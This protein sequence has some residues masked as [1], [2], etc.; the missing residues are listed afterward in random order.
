MKQRQTVRPSEMIPLL[1]LSVAFVLAGDSAI[2]GPDDEPSSPL[3]RLSQNLL[4]IQNNLTNAKLKV[5][6]RMGGAVSQN[7]GT[8]AENGE[9]SKDRRPP[10]PAE[11]CC[12]SNL[13]LIQKRFGQL[14]REVESLYLYYADRNN[15]EALAVLNQIQGEMNT[16]AQGVAVFKMA[17][18]VDRAN[19]A[20]VGIIRPFNR[21]RE[22]IE[23][24][25]ACCPVDAAARGGSK[26]AKQP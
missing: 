16:V 1:I 4:G 26:A 24:L 23:Q 18:T 25:Q 21:L 7:S 11:A 13:E 9:D 15:S 5:R 10:T 3:D 14:H 12:S 20:M 19:Q 2:A 6:H 8:G 17:G 22:A